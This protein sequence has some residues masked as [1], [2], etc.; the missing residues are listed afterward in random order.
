MKDSFTR[1]LPGYHHV[2]SS[3]Y[4]NAASH[5][6][7]P[8]YMKSIEDMPITEIDRKHTHKVDTIK[9]YCESMYKLG[10]FAP[11]PRKAALVGPGAKK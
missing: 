4:T 10:L 9:D 6:L 7:H 3:C 1:V 11:Q 2:P 5:V 8:Q